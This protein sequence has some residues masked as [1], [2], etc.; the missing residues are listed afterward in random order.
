MTTNNWDETYATVIRNMLNGA[1][2]IA[3]PGEEGNY[4]SLDIRF[5]YGLNLG[6]PL[7][8]ARKVD[9]DKTKFDVLQMLLNLKRE[10][11]DEICNGLYGQTTAIVRLEGFF[12]EYDLVF[13]R[14]KNVLTLIANV[15]DGKVVN[16]PELTARLALFLELIGRSTSIKNLA[17]QFNYTFCRMNEEEVAVLRELLEKETYDLPIVAFKKQT[18]AYDY[19]PSYVTLRN[20]HYSE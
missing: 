12:E 11:I 13:E 4:R 7:L 20:Y 6:F 3:E 19:D 2:N 15:K 16:I 5:S 14:V 9:F 10:K 18:S 8:T 1:T 17:L